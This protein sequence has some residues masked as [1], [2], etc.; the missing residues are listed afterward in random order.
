MAVTPRR[1]REIARTRQDILEA[2]AR[3]F[4]TRGF[5]T[6]T[7][8]DIAREA[9]YTAASLYSYFSSKEEI[10]RE[11]FASITVERKAALEKA[12]PEGMT[13]RQKLELMVRRQ[14]EVAMKHI[15]AIRFF[16]FS[17]AITAGACHGESTPT[18]FESTATDFA[19]FFEQH[20]APGDL[21]SWSAEDAALAFSGMT[22]LFFLRWLR[23][24]EGGIDQQI[25]RFLDLFFHGIC[26]PN[27]Q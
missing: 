7:M 1:A 17:G 9:G 23:T 22:H 19:R 6:A 10:I 5:T 24:G 25:P 18:T 13:F 16:Y 15:D 27:P 4:A 12:M 2:A 3:A 21:G 8:Q 26:G 11:L 20:A 14:L